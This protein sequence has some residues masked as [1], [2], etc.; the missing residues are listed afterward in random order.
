[1]QPIMI[2]AKVKAE[3][4]AEV[5]AAAKKL[6][7]ALEREQPEG[8]RYAS[9]K[10]PD[11]VSFVILLQ[12]GDGA[13]NPLAALPEFKEFQEGLKSYLA[14]PPTQEQLTVIGSYRFFD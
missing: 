3:S 4:V 2:R 12:L 8:I 9:S 6:F 11:G 14:E 5:E 13:G 1:M 7:S 10:L